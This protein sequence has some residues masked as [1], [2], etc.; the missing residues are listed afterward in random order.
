MQTL[1]VIQSSFHPKSEAAAEGQAICNQQRLDL[2]QF[3]G[4]SLHNRF[5]L[6]Y[7]KKRQQR[8]ASR[9]AARCARQQFHSSHQAIE[10]WLVS[11]RL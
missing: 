4:H 1:P 7:E 6:D 11:S 5:S 8:P 9:R 2:K 10:T 3:A